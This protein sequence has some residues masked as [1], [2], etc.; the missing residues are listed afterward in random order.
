MMLNLN[1]SARGGGFPGAILLGAIFLTPLDLIHRLEIQ[2][3][4]TKLRHFSSNESKGGGK[5]VPRS[6]DASPFKSALDRVIV[7]N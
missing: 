3:A 7:L 2:K 4:K 1:F 6:T 5:N